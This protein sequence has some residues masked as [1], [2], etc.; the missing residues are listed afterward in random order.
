MS[1]HDLSDAEV[2]ALRAAEQMRKS[3]PAGY[4]AWIAKH[5]S[6]TTSSTASPGDTPPTRHVKD[7][8]PAE[9]KAI[10]A[11]RGIH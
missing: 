8:S 1:Q 9:R 6:A 7:M 11:K 2:T 5:G 4:A 10:L 3:D